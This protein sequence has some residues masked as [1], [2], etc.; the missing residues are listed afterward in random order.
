MRTAIA[1]SALCEKARGNSNLRSLP[2][3]APGSEGRPHVPS[4]RVQPRS[5]A[6]FLNA[7][8]ITE[9][10][11]RGNQGRAKGEATAIGQ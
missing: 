4:I 2:V 1:A 7:K 9:G 3:R 10:R 5:F 11:Q 8:G 6:L